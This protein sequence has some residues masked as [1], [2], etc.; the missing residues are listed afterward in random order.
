MSV[1]FKQ[2]KAIAAENWVSLAEPRQQAAEVV[3]CHPQWLDKDNAL[4]KTVF[5][6]TPHALDQ[7]L[8]EN[9]FG[10][11][12]NALEVGDR[13]EVN[14]GLGVG[15]T[16][17]GHAMVVATGQLLEFA[18]LVVSRVIPSENG[19]DAAVEVLPLAVVRDRGSGREAA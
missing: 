17:T 15:S 1:S 12:S 7:V 13:I 6:R 5:V 9:Y 14:C 8:G 2:S 11:L 10:R 19:V 4:N 3:R 16:G 18:T